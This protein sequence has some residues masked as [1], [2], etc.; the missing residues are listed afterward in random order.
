MIQLPPELITDENSPQFVSFGRFTKNNIMMQMRK[1][2]NHPFLVQWPINPKT[3]DVIVDKDIIRSSGKMRALDELLKQLYIRKHR[4]L[5]FSQMTKMLDI[6]EEYCHYRRY[7][8]RRLDG[9]TNLDI[10]RHYINEFNR[11]D[12]IFLFL[13]STRAGGLGNY[14]FI[15][16]LKL[17]FK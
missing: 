16:T 3:G 6:I 11:N 12:D 10:R 13:I 2:T 15:N 5:L 4:V 1:I 17:I 7:S 8:Y 14:L 9:S